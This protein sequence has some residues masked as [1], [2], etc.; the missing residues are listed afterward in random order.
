M[1]STATSTS[2]LQ[3]ESLKK[4]DV[5][6]D[7]Q[8][9]SFEELGKQLHQVFGSEKGKKDN[10]SSQVRNLQQ[11]ASTATRFSDIE[12]FIKNQ[13]GRG[14]NDNEWRRC[15]DSLLKSLQELRQQANQIEKDD[16]ELQRQL[17]LHLARGWAR[18]IVSAYLYQ[19]AIQEMRG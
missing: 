14:S 13:M 7:D 10:V 2:V 8:Y 11:I 17:R 15:G 5:Y 6:L 19:K 1:S 3:A 4:A 16:R 18:A 12:C 9:R